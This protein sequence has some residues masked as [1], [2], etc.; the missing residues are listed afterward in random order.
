MD[1]MRKIPLKMKKEMAEDPFMSSCC[2]A[3][4]H[5][6]GRIE[7]HHCFIY[8][9]KQINEKWA[10]VPLCGFHHSRAEIEPFKSAIC[11]LSLS[12]ASRE[13]LDK[14]PRKDWEQMI[15]F[16]KNCRSLDQLSG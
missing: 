15:S 4:E 8:V 3:D 14:Y 13:D 1:E 16:Y 9:S 11:R 6:G 12:R 5:C 2:I 7:W 10:I